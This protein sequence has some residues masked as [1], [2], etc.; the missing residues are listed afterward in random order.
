M[1][2]EFD[3]NNRHYQELVRLAE[4]DRLDVPADPNLETFGGPLSGHVDPTKGTSALWSEQDLPTRFAEACRRNPR[5][6]QAWK[7]AREE[8][9]NRQ[10]RLE[11][12]VTRRRAR[13]ASGTDEGLA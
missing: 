1:A 13:I 10:T 9:E 7:G 2:D 5:L 11:T 3:F 12:E 8:A 4:G 6:V